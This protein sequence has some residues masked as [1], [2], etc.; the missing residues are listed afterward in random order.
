MPFGKLI[1]LVASASPFLS[2]QRAPRPPR[3]PLRLPA[4]AKRI[5]VVEFGGVDFASVSTRQNPG[6][7]GEWTVASPE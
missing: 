7:C 1:E 6:R 3:F 4:T 5:S 2:R